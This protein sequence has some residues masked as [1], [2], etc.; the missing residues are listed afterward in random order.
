MDIVGYSA[1][2]ESN[3]VKAMKSVGIFR[4]ETEKMVPTYG[5]MIVQFYGDGCLLSFDS[6]SQ[7]VNCMISLQRNFIENGVPVRIGLH[8]GEVVFSE[9]N[10]YGDGVNVASRIESAGQAGSILF[11]KSVRDQIK[12]KDHYDIISMGLFSFKNIAEPMEVYALA[13]KGFTI[14]Q[15]ETQK[16]NTSEILTR[17]KIWILIVLILI[18]AGFSFF[19]LHDK[20]V[21]IDEENLTIAVLPFTHESIDQQDEFFTSG[22]HTDVLTRLASVQDFRIISKSTVM[23]YKGYTGDMRDLGSRLNAK[24]ILEG[25]V[26]RWQDQVRITT[27][28]IE[29]KTN[30]VIWSDEF[31]ASLNNVFEL[32]SRIATEISQKLQANLSEQEIL[33]LEKAPTTIMAAY[34][35]YLKAIHILEQP[36]PSYEQ[37]LQVIKLLESAVEADPEFGKAWARLVQAYS[38]QLAQLSRVEG[39]DEEKSNVR[40]LARIALDMAKKV[41]PEG[42]EVL[43]EQAIYE[44]QVNGDRLLALK[45]FEKA[46]ER[47]P[48]D[49]YSLFQLSILYSTLGDPERAIE[50]LER[51]FELTQS[52]GRVSYSLTYAYEVTG[53]YEDMVPLLHRLYELYPSEKRYLVE[54][55][56]YQFLHDGKLE[57]YHAFENTLK[58]VEAANPWDERSIQ[59]KEMVVAMFNDEF[60]KYHEY[61]IGKS[62]S[63]IQGHGNW[64]CPLVANE[65]AN[66]VRLLYQNGYDQEGDELLSELKNIVLRPVNYNSVCI[67]DANV[68]LPKLDFLAGDTLDARTKLEDIAIDVMKNNHFPIGAV[69]RSVLVQAAD[70]IIPEKVYSYY[71]KAIKNA[72]SITSFESI[73]SDPWTYPN[74]IRDPKFVQEIRK[75]GRF[76]EFLQEYGF[77]EPA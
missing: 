61:W 27:Q 37:I 34:D 23:D 53:R 62:E 13:N 16:S 32:Q 74:L 14:P 58:T 77:L 60:N 19:N 51:G 42:W 4:Q 15:K 64:T 18:L 63:H 21:R 33:E 67:F 26:R 69:E 35:S 20:K 3:E 56:Y 71:E 9:K 2:M 73:C 40:E 65:H 38:E 8:L 48:S 46:I 17:K 59:N 70:L 39:N 49:V 75:D 45:L 7:A 22:V 72:Q 57:S 24:Y 1:M 66:H 44:M 76:V 11:S 36:R 54:A 25:G 6:T 50:M 31:N 68:Y 5:G 28:L 43:Q 30:Q 52:N 55:K 41:A 12:N 10:I 29:S 47:N